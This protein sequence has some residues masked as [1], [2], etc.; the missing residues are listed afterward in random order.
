LLVAYYVL[1][2]KEKKIFMQI[3]KGLKT[4]TWYSITLKKSIHMETSKLKEL[5]GHDYD[6]LMKQFYLYVYVPSCQGVLDLLSF[7][8]TM[9]FGDHV[10]KQLI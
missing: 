5:K 3:I 10:Q 1:D 6:V 9:C 4:L 7:T 8:W 2:L